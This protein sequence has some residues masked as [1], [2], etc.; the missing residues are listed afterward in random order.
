MNLS[1]SLIIF[2]YNDENSINP[3]L[4]FKDRIITIKVGGY[5]AEEKLSLCKDYIIPELLPQ[6]NMK[7]EDITFE[8]DVLKTIIES[9]SKEKGV[10][11]IKRV[12]N[13]I[14]SWIN[15]MKYI[16]IDNIVTSCRDSVYCQ[17]TSNSDFP[18]VRPSVK[19]TPTNVSCEA[20]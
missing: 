6:Y 1:N 18:A 7:K 13:N 2:T 5:N 16:S 12:L 8:D 10:R 19:R 20:V 11:N 17:S 9:H 14:V 3:I 4:N 15:M